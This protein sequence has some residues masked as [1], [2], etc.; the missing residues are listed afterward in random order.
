MLGQSAGG[1]LDSVLL[2]C[3][4]ARLRQGF[5]AG[6]LSMLLA[7]KRPVPVTLPQRGT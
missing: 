5:G 2:T 6:M 7:A 1:R 4:P 3:G